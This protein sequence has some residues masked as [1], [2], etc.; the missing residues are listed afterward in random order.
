MS[1]AQDRDSAKLEFQVGVAAVDVTPAYPVRLNGFGGRREEA[2]GT[3][4]RLWAKALAISQGT[5]APVVIITLDSL[6][7]RE[8]LVDQVAAELSQR[9]QLPRENLVLTFT[10]TH[11]AP[12]VN[13]SSDTIFSTPIPAEHLEHIDRYT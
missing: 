11:S 8:W 10:H 7:V 2:A 6:G 5:D 12:K 13:G 3:S 1:H 9:Y 4:Q